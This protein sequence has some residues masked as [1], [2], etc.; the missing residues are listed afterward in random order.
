LRGGIVKGREAAQPCV[1]R[2]GSLIVDL[3][4]A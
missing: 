2:P 4:A 3:K 1:P